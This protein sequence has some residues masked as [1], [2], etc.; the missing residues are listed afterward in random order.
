MRDLLCR[1]KKVGRIRRSCQPGRGIKGKANSPNLLETRKEI[2]KPAKE[3]QHTE[4]GCNNCNSAER[5][6]GIK[7]YSAASK[8]LAAGIIGLYSMTLIRFGGVSFALIVFMSSIGYLFLF[9]H[10]YKLF[11]KF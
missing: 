7:L 5:N 6:V 4:Q 1:V 10:K 9:I 11:S 2:A 3:N 8:W